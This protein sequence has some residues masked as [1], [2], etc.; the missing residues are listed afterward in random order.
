SA[1]APDDA[2]RPETPPRAGVVAPLDSVASPSEKLKA[3]ELASTRGKLYRVF[4]GTVIE[5]VLTNRLDGSF[6][7]PVNCM[8]TTT[9]YSHDGQHVLIPQGTRILGEVKKLE[10]FGQQ[11]LAVIFHRLIMPNGYSLS[12]DKFQG[13]NQ[14]GETGL[15]DQ[16]NHHYLQIFG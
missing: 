10:T 13:L 12:L 14:V 1:P 15:R 11:R 7:G 6:S 5:T 8:A 16:I 9:I 2:L 3:K 4:E